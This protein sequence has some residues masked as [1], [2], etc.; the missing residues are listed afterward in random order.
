MLPFK[1]LFSVFGLSVLCLP[2]ASTAF[3]GGDKCHRHRRVDVD[4]DS[5]KAE[6]RPEGPDLA[7]CAHYKIEVDDARPGDRFVLMLRLSEC[8]RPL[9]DEQGRPFTATVPLPPACKDDPDFKGHVNITLPAEMVRCPDRLK[10]HGCVTLAGHP[11]PLADRNAGVK[12]KGHYRPGRIEVER[13]EMEPVEMEPA[14]MNHN[15]QIRVNGR[16]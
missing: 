5:L 12:F 8:G 9:L 4:F 3:A 6:M 14:K 7:L 15:F 16:R 13:V 10:L 2:L 1:K 11:A